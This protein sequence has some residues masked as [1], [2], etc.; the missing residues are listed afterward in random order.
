MNELDKKILEL[1]R[2]LL[3]SG[4]KYLTNID[5]IRSSLNYKIDDKSISL[6]FRKRL[7]TDCA[8]P[9]SYSV[10]EKMA[11]TMDFIT[12]CESTSLNINNWE[13]I[14]EYE[15]SINGK[16]YHVPDLSRIEYARALDRIDAILEEKE[17][18]N[19]DSI[20]NELR[21]ESREEL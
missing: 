7:R 15:I 2:F 17:S 9:N 13:K 3:Y 1:F 6:S 4:T 8:Q 16:Y 5:Y 11:E 21:T 10:T 19:L 20:L 18:E 12:I 14:V